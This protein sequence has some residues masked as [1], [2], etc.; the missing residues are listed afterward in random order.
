MM[1]TVRYVNTPKWKTTTFPET[2]RW[3]TWVP[4]LD[5]DELDAEGP[6]GTLAKWLEEVFV[7][8]RARKFARIVVNGELAKLHLL[9]DTRPRPRRCAQ[10][11]NAAMVRLGYFVDAE[12]WR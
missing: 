10:R 3:P 1:P 9:G 11:W 2:A 6:V 4:L 12:D 8:P 5:E 7:D